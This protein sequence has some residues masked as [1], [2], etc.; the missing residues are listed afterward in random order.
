MGPQDSQKTT[1]THLAEEHELISHCVHSTGRLTGS[2]QQAERSAPATA[3]GES[4][5]TPLIDSEEIDPISESFSALAKQHSRRHENPVNNA[6]HTVADV[7]DVGGLVAAII[8][9]R[10]RVVVI[11]LHSRL[12]DRDGR[13]SFPTGD[14][15]RRPRRGF[16]P[17]D[18]GPPSRRPPPLCSPRL[19]GHGEGHQVTL[20]KP[21]RVGRGQ[22]IPSRNASDHP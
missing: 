4:G 6:L 11:G 2:S 17:S 1:P 18:L 22:P 21:R 12:R 13:P 14:L 20:G 3:A 16:P 15:A 19:I 5:V 9:R 7:V 10:I 8:T